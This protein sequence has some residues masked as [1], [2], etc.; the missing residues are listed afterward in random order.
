M[1]NNIAQLRGAQSAERRAPRVTSMGFDGV[2][3]AFSD[4]FY[5]GRDF[6]PAFQSGPFTSEANSI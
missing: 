2:E 6:Q 1:A 4:G 3:I 5:W